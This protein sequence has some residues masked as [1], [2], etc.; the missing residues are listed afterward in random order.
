MIALRDDEIA[1]ELMKK[2][3]KTAVPQQILFRRIVCIINQQLLQDHPQLLIG[4][5]LSLLCRIT[6]EQ[7]IFLSGIGH[8]KGLG[9]FQDTKQKILGASKPLLQ[10]E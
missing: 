8:K 2:P 5:P 4:L 3:V 6:P 1:Y 7:E 10:T 9:D